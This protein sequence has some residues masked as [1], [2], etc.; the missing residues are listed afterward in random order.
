MNHPLVEPP[1]K[2]DKWN[3][4]GIEKEPI[5]SVPLADLNLLRTFLAVAELKNFTAAAERLRLARPQVSLQVRR[6]ET[7]L[8]TSLFHRT[9]RRVT[10]T[11]AGQ[12]L[13]EQCAPLLTGIE[14]VV[15]QAASSEAGLRG[16]LRV[17][18]PVENAVHVV[19]PVVAAFANRF[20]EVRV[21]LLV[22]DRIQDIVAEGIDVSIRVG[23]LRESSAR[24]SRLGEFEQAVL[25]SPE[26]LALHRAPESPEQLAQHRWIALTLLPAPLTWSFSRRSKSVTVRM[27]PHLRT[28][29]AVALRAL[30]LSGAGISV[31]SLLHLESDVRKGSLV[32]VL[33][34][35]SLPGGGVHAVYPP[36][37]QVSP[38]ARAFVELLKT[39]ML[40]RT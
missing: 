26:Y 32:R 40:R 36:G 16:R 31:G 25:A 12:R 17:S 23:W 29:S 10:L 35:W 5:M 9:T 7:M 1:E 15:Q 28:D 13:F 24:V 3:I 2:V 14:Q 4:T 30:L 6:M 39:Q 38:V 20:P 11:D 37:A 19:A 33:P 27:N 8:G 34:E 22:S 18:A 21:E